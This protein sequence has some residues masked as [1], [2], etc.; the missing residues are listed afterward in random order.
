MAA[1]GIFLAEPI[2]TLFGVEADVVAEGAAYMRIQ[3]AGSVTMFLAMIAQF[4]MQASG[5]R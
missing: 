2:L 3:L 4:V 5:D 1:I